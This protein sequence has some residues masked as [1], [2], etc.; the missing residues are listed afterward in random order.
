MHF[1]I[2]SVCS[3]A[4][5]NNFSIFKVR[6]LINFTATVCQSPLQGDSEDLIWP[7]EVISEHE[8]MQNVTHPDLEFG[9]S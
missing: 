6:S 3:N 9:S 8:L 7:L 1:A 5:C 2:I 4:F